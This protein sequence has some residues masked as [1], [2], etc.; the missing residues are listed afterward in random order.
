MIQKDKFKP[1]L[2]D[3]Y[4]KLEPLFDNGEMQKIYSFLKERGDKGHKIFP[5]PQ[6]TFRAFTETPLSN[7][8]V[9]M[10]GM[11]PYHNVHDNIP[12]ADG[13]LM[14]CSNHEKYISPSLE[15][16]YNA[17]ETE[18]EEGLCLPC[19]RTGDVSF[20]SHQGV[21]M[22]NAALTVEMGKP[23]SHNPVWKEFISYLFCEIIGFLDCPVVLLGKEA[24]HFYGYLGI[25]QWHFS[26]SH[27]ASASY[28]GQKWDSEGVFTKVN[29][30]LTDKGEDPIKWILDTP[31]F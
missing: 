29:K 11:C 30:I 23:G 24:E 13:L 19:I 14:G 17:V 8:K 6:Q 12:V 27:P 20:L 26:L 3:W 28:K 10:M 31:P 7:V 21:L 2:G 15:Q 1:L 18:F 16:Y 25:L 22:L 5:R 4:E 9:V